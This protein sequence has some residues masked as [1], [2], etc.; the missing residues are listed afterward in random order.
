MLNRRTRLKLSWRN[1]SCAI[2]ALVIQGRITN[3]SYKLKQFTGGGNSAPHVPIEHPDQ[4]SIIQTEQHPFFAGFDKERKIYSDAQEFEPVCGLTDT[5]LPP[6]VSSCRLQAPPPLVHRTQT[7]K[8]FAC[9]L[10][11]IDAGGLRQVGT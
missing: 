4:S 7:D 11:Q 2:E 1:E 3:G 8:S 6:E 5:R 9:S 10:Q